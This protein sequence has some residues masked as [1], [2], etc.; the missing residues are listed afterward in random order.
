[1]TTPEIT[2]EVQAYIDSKI[3]AGIEAANTPAPKLTQAETEAQ[4]E[5]IR[6]NHRSVADSHRLQGRPN[7]HQYAAW[8]KEYGRSRP[9]GPHSAEAFNAA[10]R[11]RFGMNPGDA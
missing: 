2:P 4:I 11:E 7:A 8:V 3:A 5:E 1:M 9:P 10:Y 6:A